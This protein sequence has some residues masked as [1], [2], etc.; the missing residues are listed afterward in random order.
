MI[1]EDLPNIDDN[2]DHDKLNVE[3]L[4]METVLSNVPNVL[5]VH[6]RTRLAKILYLT[7][8]NI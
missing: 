1:V 7:I 5:R 6:I 2:D 4:R 8:V 3:N